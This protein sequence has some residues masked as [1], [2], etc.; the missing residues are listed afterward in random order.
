MIDSAEIGD[1][2]LTVNEVNELAEAHNE[3]FEPGFYSG[4][5]PDEAD[6]RNSWTA[7]QETGALESPAAR[8][9]S[10]SGNLTDSE[11]RKKAETEKR[12]AEKREADK[13][14]ADKREADKRK[15]HR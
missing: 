4:P 9:K 3:G 12:E 1:R 6:E 2:I 7:Q 5:Y 15:E 14:E 10:A 13:R 8:R 11:Q